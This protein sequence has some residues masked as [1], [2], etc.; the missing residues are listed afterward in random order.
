MWLKWL[1]HPYTLLAYPFCQL[2]PLW[3]FELVITGISHYV[4]YA[5]DQYIH[6][7]FVDVGK[8][9]LLLGSRTQD[10]YYCFTM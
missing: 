5:L 2:E 10:D 7:T 4:V 3:A 9:T 8:N 6:H 1:A